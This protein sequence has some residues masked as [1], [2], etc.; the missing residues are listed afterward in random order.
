MEFD[1]IVVGGGSAGCIVAAELCT[2]PG[3]SVLLIECGDRAEDNPETLTAD[4]YKQAFLNPRLMFERFSTPQPGCTNRRLFM[5]SGRTIG[6]S[7]A[8]NAMVY[9]RGARADFDEWPDG[10]KWRDIERDFEALEGTLRVRRRAPTQFTETCIAASEAAGFRRKEDLNDGDLSGVLGYEWMSYEGNERRSSFVSFLRER[11]GSPNLTIATNARVH[12]VKLQDRRAV[13]V[14]YREGNALVTA[15]ARRE[16]VL[17][18]GALET[19][20][21]L[22]LSGIGPLDVLRQ[23]GLPALVESRGVGENFH[24]HPNVQLFFMGKSAVDCNYPQLYGFHRAAARPDL[25]P[26]QSD[27]CY[28]FYPARSSFR[29]GVLKLLPAI[30]LPQPLYEAP[31]VVPAMRAALAGVFDRSPVQRLVERLWGIVVILGKP[32]SRGTV[33]CVSPRPEAP[34]AID[35]AYFS[36]PEDMETMVRGVELARRIAA[37]APARRFGSLEAIPGSRVSSRAAI[38]SFVQKNAMT[39]YHYAG[40]CR[41]GQGH[42]SV[43][44]ERLSVRGVKRLRIADASVI[45]T[46]PVS[47][48]NAPSMLIGYRAA[49]FIREDGLRADAV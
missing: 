31:F 12:R 8:I 42:D 34:L 33:R 36:D 26:R 37:S 22:M 47:A 14:E 5:G 13:G 19:P 40:T 3:T 35:P 23:A 24:D 18:A 21:L 6:G 44:D 17:T 27:S 25:A 32:K 30:A 7:G 48:L 38:T 46:T 49:R 28:V 39:T 4:G 15:Y 9:T 11:V 10:W 45:P 20:R 2:S 29:E 43:V 16:V 1:Y 41:M